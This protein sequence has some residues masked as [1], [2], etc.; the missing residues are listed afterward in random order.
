MKYVR[1]RCDKK[2]WLHAHRL[3]ACACV[4]VCFGFDVPV[5]IR[6]A[7]EEATRTQATCSLFVC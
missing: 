1:T 6:R 2:K 5:A 3:G 4:C 7:N